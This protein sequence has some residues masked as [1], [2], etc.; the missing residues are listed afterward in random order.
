MSRKTGGVEARDWWR[1]GQWFDVPADGG[2]TIFFTVAGALQAKTAAGRLLRVSPPI[3]STFFSRGEES[4]IDTTLEPANL[5]T[6]MADRLLR[7]PN[8][9]AVRR[10]RRR[11]CS[12]PSAEYETAA[13]HCVPGA[14]C[15][16]TAIARQR[17]AGSLWPE[18]NDTQTLTN[19][20][21]ELHHL[22]DAWPALE[23]LIVAGPRTLAWSDAGAGVDVVAFELTPSVAWRAIVTLC[24]G[25][26]PQPIRRAGVRRTDV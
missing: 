3:E 1:V 4:Q 12:F 24:T 2:R 14:P 16:N 21:R 20:R 26:S 7:N 15:R 11:P 25:C 13:A 22:T 18:S 19:L 8:S 17:V 9:S 6:W 5:A 10:R 23:A